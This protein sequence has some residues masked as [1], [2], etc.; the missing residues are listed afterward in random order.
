MSRG[1]TYTAALAAAALQVLHARVQCRLRK[2]FFRA[3]VCVSGGVSLDV[4]ADNRER[5]QHGVAP[6][7]LNVRREKGL[8]VTASGLQVHTH[9]KPEEAE[10]TAQ[11]R[12]AKRWTSRVIRRGLTGAASCVC[13]RTL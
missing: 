4:K 13:F 12:C 7:A 8:F 1:R 2:A 10:G 5:M 3:R 6:L 9:P 11:L